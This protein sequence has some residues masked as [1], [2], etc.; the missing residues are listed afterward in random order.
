MNLMWNIYKWK[1]IVVNMCARAQTF[2]FL[3]GVLFGSR[4]Q[5]I[6]STKVSTKM[7][8]DNENFQCR[9]LNTHHYNMES[10]EK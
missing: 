2:A 9:A 3:S 8:N 6:K 7:T 4:M 1:T 5:K 10:I